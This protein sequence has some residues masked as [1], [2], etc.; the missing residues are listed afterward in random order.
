MPGQD[1][2]AAAFDALAAQAAQNA[3]LTAIAGVQ[4]ALAAFIGTDSALT[5]ANSTSAGNAGQALTNRVAALSAF[6]ALAAA[7]V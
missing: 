1:D 2:G 6:Q 7:L 5:Y 4:G 3:G